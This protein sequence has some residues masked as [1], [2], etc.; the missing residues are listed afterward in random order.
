MIV[1]VKL[2]DKKFAG[3]L[4][5][6]SNEEHYLQALGMTCASK[7]GEETTVEAFLE[8]QGTEVIGLESGV[9]DYSAI[10]EGLKITVQVEPEAEAPVATPPAEGS[11]EETPPLT[12]EGG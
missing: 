3:L 8:T 5:V 9:D 1:A 7:K 6:F 4:G 11:P 12:G 10:S 2:K